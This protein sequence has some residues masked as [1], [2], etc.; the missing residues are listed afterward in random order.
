MKRIIETSKY[1]F[2]HPKAPWTKIIFASPYFSY[3]IYCFC[4]SSSSD[5]LEDI[6]PS[7]SSRPKSSLGFYL[8]A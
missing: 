8:I 5:E 2:P 1:D 7:I 3:S 4:S 6:A